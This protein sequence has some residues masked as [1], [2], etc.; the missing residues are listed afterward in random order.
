MTDIFQCCPGGA[1]VDQNEIRR[2]ENIVMCLRCGRFICGP[3]T[4][5]ERAQR[6]DIVRLRPGDVVIDAA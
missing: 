5:A 4:G 3:K 1:T 6:S 2:T